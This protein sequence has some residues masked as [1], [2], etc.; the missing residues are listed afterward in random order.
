MP[1]I[2]YICVSY[3]NAINSEQRAND[4]AVGLLELLFPFFSE[5]L[6]VLDSHYATL[7]SSAT[8]LK[9]HTARVV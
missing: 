9:L 1:R 5:D 7:S 6:A 3:V 2:N 8:T 4:P